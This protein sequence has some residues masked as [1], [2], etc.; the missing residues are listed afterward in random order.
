VSHSK[1]ATFAGRL[2]ILRFLHM[3]RIK[4]GKKR[5]PLEIGPLFTSLGSVE[6]AGPNGDGGTNTLEDIPG[7]LDGSRIP[8]GLEMF[9]AGLQV[10]EIIL[11]LVSKLLEPGIWFFKI[12][13]DTLLNCTDVFSCVKA[14]V[15][16]L[17]SERLYLYFRARFGQDRSCA[18]LG[19]NA[20]GTR[21]CFHIC[22]PGSIVN[23]DAS[24]HGWRKCAP[25]Q[26]SGLALA[27]SICDAEFLPSGALALRAGHRVPNPS[28]SWSSSGLVAC[29]KK[30]T[31]CG[32]LTAPRVSDKLKK[33]Y[34]SGAGA[35]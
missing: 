16:I 9:G 25:H 10:A 28:D 2:K 4:I 14:S 7:A 31:T 27:R 1:Q 23:C 17:G 22:G 15:P 24:K 32:A 5:G 3:G 6:K 12:C 8:E 33:S 29:L 20:S 11:G 18:V 35:L 30:S 21:R 13:S 34:P 19:S 26:V